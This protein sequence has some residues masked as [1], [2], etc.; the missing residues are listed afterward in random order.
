[1]FYIVWY[2]ESRREREWEEFETRAEAD[3]ALAVYRVRFPWNTYRL[4]EVVATVEATER[5]KPDQAFVYH[6]P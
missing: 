5:W 3:T 2:N 4:C 6:T 1:M